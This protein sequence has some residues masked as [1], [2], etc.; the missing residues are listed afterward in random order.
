MKVCILSSVHIALDNRVFYREARSLRSAGYDVTLIAVHSQDEI[1]DGIQII[2]LPRV[3]R[4]QR[5]LL[6]RKIYQLARRSGADIFHFHDPELLPLAAW[7]KRRTG[8][9]VIYDVHEAYPDFI[10]LK[11]Y[12]PSWL[13]YPLAATF[14]IAE[15]KLASLQSGLIFADDATAVDFAQVNLPK[16]TLFN[17]PGQQ[18][19]Q[20]AVATDNN[21]DNRPPHVLYLGGME[22]NRGV[23]LMVEAFALLFAAIPTAKLWL[24]GHFMPPDLE[25]IVRQA[26][27]RYGLEQAVTITGRV[28]FEQIGQYL[29]QARV[30]WVPWQ[31]VAKNQKNIP[32]KL[33]EYMAY[34]LPIVGSDLPSIRPFLKDGDNG[35]LVPSA[36]PASHAAAII[37]LLKN[38]Q[39]AAA[40]GLR[41]QLRVRRQYNW[42]VMEE[43]LLRLYEELLGP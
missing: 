6:W 8:K 37:N 11:D 28:D 13:R 35:Y 42:A 22:R 19:V 16:A 15:P 2:G 9:P 14:R 3:A 24:V 30:G 31:A 32:T 36:D 17:F 29:R 18:F 12:L 33:F 43:R 34:A 27:T 38:P 4:W 25:H 23:E 1:K 10:E 39:T 20:T 7:L 40:M 21:Y 41:G 5:P 26:V